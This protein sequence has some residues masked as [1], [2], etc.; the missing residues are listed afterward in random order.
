MSKRPLRG[1]QPRWRLLGPTS[2]RSVGQRYMDA[3][4]RWL[5]PTDLPTAVADLVVVPC[6][7]EHFQ[8]CDL[9]FSGLDSSVAGD[10]GT[11]LGEAAAG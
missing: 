1:T 9:V 7:P 10:V 11:Q 2:D 8:E 3:V 4:R 5:L 6:Q